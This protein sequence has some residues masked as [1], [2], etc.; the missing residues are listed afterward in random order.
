MTLP[1]SQTG[2]LCLHATHGKEL[3]E[4]VETTRFALKQLTALLQGREIPAAVPPVLQVT[5]S[6]TGDVSRLV[7]LRKKLAY[8]FFSRQLPLLRA[9]QVSNT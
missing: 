7:I 8:L 2:R 6:Y 4:T 9:P 3:A 5:Y 1:P